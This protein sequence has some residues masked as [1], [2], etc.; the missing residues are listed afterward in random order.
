MSRRL[1]ATIVI[2]AAGLLV[3]SATA[4]AITRF[5]TPT[6]NIACAGDKREMRCDIRVTNATPPPRPASCNFDWGQAYVI[7][8][9]KRKGRGL[10]A[11]D[12]VLPSPG[13]RIRILRYGTSIRFGPGGQ[14]VCISR[15]TGLTCRNKAGHGFTLSRQAIRLF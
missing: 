5:A 6:R 13:Q 10:C 2:A 3:W 15:R 11:S 12:T 7:T 4:T 14:I 9:G 1:L 8:P